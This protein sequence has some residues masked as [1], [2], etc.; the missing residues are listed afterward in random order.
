MRP[1]S[2]YFNDHELQQRQTYIDT[3]PDTTQFHNAF[4]SDELWQE[5]Q[6]LNWF[7]IWLTDGIFWRLDRAP[8]H[9]YTVVQLKLTR[10]LCLH[11]RIRGTPRYVKEIGL[12]KST[13]HKYRRLE[14]CWVANT[15]SRTHVAHIQHT[16]NVRQVGAAERS[17]SEL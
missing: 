13:N 3:N 15:T 9:D 4:Q 7:Q 6:K 14:K 17:K 12:E 10:A 16:C 8:I 2:K 11:P 1:P 5:V